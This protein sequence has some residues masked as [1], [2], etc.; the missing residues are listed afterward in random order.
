[1][2]SRKV[3]ENGNSQQ[4]KTAERIKM[5]VVLGFRYLCNS[6]A[7]NTEAPAQHPTRTRRPIRGV[8]CG[9]VGVKWW[10]VVM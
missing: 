5:C 7:T 6:L 9:L 8:E 4:R 2:G 1:M 3:M 10:V